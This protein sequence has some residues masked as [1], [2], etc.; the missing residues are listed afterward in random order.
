MSVTPQ[1]PNRDGRAGGR[2]RRPG[3]RVRAFLVLLA[4]VSAATAFAQADAGRTPLPPAH[5]GE[6]PGWHGFNL[7][8]KFFLSS[9]SKPFR[10]DD[11]RLISRLGFNFVRLPMDYRIWIRDGD[12]EQLDEAVLAEI[13]Q[14]VAWGGTYGIH[15]MINFHRAPGYTVARPAEPRN[16]WTDPEAQRVCALHWAA[17]ARRYR[18]IPNQRLSFNLFNEPPAISQATY[19]AVAGI[20]VDAIRN[21]DP[22][23]LIVADGFHWGVQPAPA[24]RELGV[25][26]A[27]RGYL[28]M[29]V[30]HYQASWAGGEQYAV[31][32]WPRTVAYGL[33]LGPSKREA[34]GPLVLEGDFGPAPRLR[35]HLKTVSNRADV[36][37]R[38][39]GQLAWV[40][41]F[42][43]GPGQGDWAEAVYVERYDIYQN[44]YDRDYTIELPPDTKRVDISVPTGDWVYFSEIGIRPN[45][46]ESA[47]DVLPLD[48]EW[49]K[50]PEPIRYRAGKDSSPYTGAERQDRAWL[51]D[52]QVRP[53]QTLRDSGVGVMVG[54]F[55]AHNRTP[56]DVTLRWME[57]NLANWRKAG[58]G[59]ALWNFRGSFGILES[60]RADV[61]YEDWEGHQL[62]RKM[63]TLLQRYARPE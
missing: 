46:P 45:G 20:M 39:D 36:L 16:L 23:R 12:W 10:E 44:R 14:A 55:G 4:A 60:G 38:A 30:S 25:A 17:F 2:G 53:W 22:N 13:D 42:V 57:D 5:A 7:Q 51:W 37:V 18:G 31:P 27:S 56:H 24:L 11:F 9:R 63:L 50:V 6:L 58:F 15:V 33:L 3:R 26:Q 34:K 52:H 48:V 19:R 59:W 62:D 47:E 28:P 54:E 41:Q 8:E 32:R 1:S 40:R 43:C 29:Q 21:E 35:L 61:D 49:G